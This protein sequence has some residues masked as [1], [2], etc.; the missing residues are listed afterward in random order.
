MAG[1][2]DK[3]KGK[4]KEATGILIGDKELEREGKVDQAVGRAKEVVE[5][6]VSKVRDVKDRAK[7]AAKS[8]Q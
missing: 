7:K 1:K 5:K 3:L 8:L 6:V 4:V 2:R